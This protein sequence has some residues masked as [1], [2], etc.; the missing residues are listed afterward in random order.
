[1]ALAPMKAVHVGLECDDDEHQV[2]CG[3]EGPCV[4]VAK[5]NPAGPLSA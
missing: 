2:D 5:E 3:N 4:P 1:M